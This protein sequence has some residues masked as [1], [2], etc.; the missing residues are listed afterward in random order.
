[1]VDK[2][3]AVLILYN[4]ETKQTALK[5]YNGFP[6][7]YIKDWEFYIYYHY[8][9]HILINKIEDDRYNVVSFNILL[10]SKKH[11]KEEAVCPKD[12]KS[13]FLNLEKDSQPLV[14][15]YILFT[16]DDVYEYSDITLASRLGSYKMAPADIH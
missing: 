6:L 16:Y 1:M 13:I 11:N 8:Q 7:S 3:P 2:L 10:L 4:E 9:I 15:G 14:E 5:Y 12:S